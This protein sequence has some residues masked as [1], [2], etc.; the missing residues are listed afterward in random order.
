M[1]FKTE[2]NPH[3]KLTRMDVERIKTLIKQGI[4]AK[5]IASEFKVHPSTI[6]RIKR[7]KTWK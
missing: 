6:S 1:P 7:S 4:P 3:V 5:D 2:T